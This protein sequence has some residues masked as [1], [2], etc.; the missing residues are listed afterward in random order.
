MVRQKTNESL[1]HV[2]MW[3]VDVSKLVVICIHI[4]ILSEY[5]YVA[6]H[7]IMGRSGGGECRIYWGCE[8]R[9]EKIHV[10]ML[11]HFISL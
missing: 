10:L 6:L 2:H 5:V 4:S 7:C 3:L 11:S 1:E 8:K 9:R